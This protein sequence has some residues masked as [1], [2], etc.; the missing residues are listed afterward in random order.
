M[1][2]I[3]TPHCMQGLWWEGPNIIH[4]ESNDNMSHLIFN[5]SPFIYS[6]GWAPVRLAC[7]MFFPSVDPLTLLPC[8]SSFSPG[9][10]DGW[11]PRMGRYMSY[12]WL[13]REA[14]PLAMDQPSAMEQSRDF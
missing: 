13:R 2:L 9:C 6:G 4:C 1:F 14:I 10:S 7:L 3:T 12:A 11:L 8:H 5:K